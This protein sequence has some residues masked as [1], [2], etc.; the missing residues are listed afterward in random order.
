MIQEVD[1]HTFLSKTS[2]WQWV[3]HTQTQGWIEAFLQER[4]VRYFM[5]EN[6]ACMGWV[7]RKWGRRMLTVNGECFRTQQ[8]SNKQVFAFF[9]H[10]SKIDADF[11]SV[12]SDS[13]YSADYEVGIRQAGFL[14]PVGMFSTT[15]S[16]VV[17]LD[18]PYVFDKSWQRNLKQADESQLSFVP[19]VCS[20]QAA[21]EYVRLH[22]EMEQRKGFNDGLTV[23][24]LRAILA[25]KCFRLAW[26]DDKDGSHLAG[27]IVYQRGG[28]G[29]F[30]YSFT[31][32]AG[33]EKSASYLLYKGW[34]DNLCREGVTRFDLGRLS[35][36]KHLKNNLY[37]FKNGIGG[38]VVSYNGEW[39]YT[40]S[41]W[42]PFAMYVANKY[43][44][45]R[46]QV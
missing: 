25:Q 13:A 7:S 6:I 9:E 33:R 28:Y 35:P 37:L 1:L 19:A 44:W 10:L 2:D 46:V 45:K 43:Y 40:S 20:E 24:Q 12:N 11:V 36:S 41:R 3:S 17:P 22:N 26:V 16:K 5:S 31:T 32:P 23:G 29:R 21:D 38:E 14:R 34:M 18:Q 27:G 4:D 39:I 42:L 15:L 30:L 8:I